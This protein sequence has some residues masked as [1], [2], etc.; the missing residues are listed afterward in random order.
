MV[1]A[2]SD[3]WNPPIKHRKVPEV[4]IQS[5]EALVRKHQLEKLDHPGI[6]A[7]IGATVGGAVGTATAGPAVGAATAAVG[8]SAAAAMTKTLPTVAEKARAT[9]APL[10]GREKDEQEVTEQKLD[11]EENLIALDSPLLMRLYR[12]I[13][14]IPIGSAENTVDDKATYQEDIHKFIKRHTA[15]L[16]EFDDRS[17]YVVDASWM[18]RRAMHW[19]RLM[20]QIRPYYAVKANPNGV[21]M[22][23]AAALDMGFD[24]ASNEELHAAVNTLRKILAM[25]QYPGIEDDPNI[26]LP[27]LEDTELG[28]HA[29]EEHFKQHPIRDKN[30][31]D[32]FEKILEEEV[33]RRV[34]FTN[35]IKERGHIKFAREAGVRMTVV[36]DEA[37]I[38]KIAKYWPDAQIIVRI[39]ADDRHSKSS[40]AT[41]FGG[42]LQHAREIIRIARDLG[43]QLIGVSFHVGTSSFDT[44]AYT[45]AIEDARRMFGWAKEIGGFDMTLLDIGGGFPGKVEHSPNLDEFAD[46]IHKAIQENFSDIPGLRIVSEPGR[47]F[48]TECQTLVACVMGK[49]DTAPFEELCDFHDYDEAKERESKAFHQQVFEKMDHFQYYINDGVYNTFTPMLFERESMFD[50]YTLLD[51]LPETLSDRERERI[52]KLEHDE[53][54]K[55]SLKLKTGEE[56]KR[57]L[58]FQPANKF[59]SKTD[60]NA[61]RHGRPLYESTIFGPTCDSLDCIGKAVRLPELDIGDWLYFLDAGAYTNSSTSHFN[62]FRNDRAVYTYRK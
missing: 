61:H 16:D 52:S 46:T 43:L 5:R 20:P 24:C 32:R 13:E 41:K 25:Q 17:F 18:A 31:R 45:V 4:L 51:P 1:E 42:D 38:H 59:G 2:L 7:A 54:V 6:G 47:L 12:H 58:G 3:P 23:V 35:S 36:D 21:L 26:Y 40:F 53:K 22:Q 28:K 48:C 49:R 11:R 19:H 37:E 60:K 56:V 10:L 29:I 9:V 62:G 33:G 14:A 55:N 50:V 44:H 30:E 15:S 57:W 27:K 39:V 8:A 34:I